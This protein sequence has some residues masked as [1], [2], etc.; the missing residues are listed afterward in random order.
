MEIKCK[1][2]SRRKKNI[3]ETGHLLPFFETSA[4]GTLR[5]FNEITDS[6]VLCKEICGQRFKRVA[7]HTEFI[8]SGGRD[9][10]IDKVIQL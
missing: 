4:K 3:S 7:D 1:T 10:L 9:K 2:Q 5:D 6:K 8:D